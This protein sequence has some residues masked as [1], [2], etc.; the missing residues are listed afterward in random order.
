MGEFC[1]ECKK[2]DAKFFCSACRI[3]SY[4]DSTCQKNNFPM[5]KLVC[6]VLADTYP[7]SYNSAAKQI[8]TSDMFIIHITFINE[9]INR[10]YSTIPGS[11]FLAVIPFVL[12]KP[13]SM[14]TLAVHIAAEKYKSLTSLTPQTLM[15][16]IQIVDRKS[17]SSEIKE[18]KVS[19]YE[20]LVRTFIID[21]ETAQMELISF[22]QPKITEKTR[23]GF[24]KNY[25]L[26]IEDF[27]QR[28]ALEPFI[29]GKLMVFFMGTFNGKKYIE[30]NMSGIMPAYAGLAK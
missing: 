13:F 10:I 27:K 29:R 11:K 21:E 26:Y 15:Y 24:E 23:E 1:Y 5:H 28:G 7:I 22:V 6:N 17:Y 30:L 4:C 16:G 12:R 9:L 2:N 3:A 18:E 14:R 20:K 25:N 8:Y 19:K